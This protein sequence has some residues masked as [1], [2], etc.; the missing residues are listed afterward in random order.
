MAS[1]HSRLITGAVILS[2][3]TPAHAQSD[4]AATED[5]E[6]C[7]QIADVMERLAC[8][9]RIGEREIATRPAPENQGL[10][11]PEAETSAATE[12][13]YTEQVAPEAEI[14]EAA[15]EDTE[16]GVLTDDVGLPKSSDDYKPILVTVVRCNKG[17]DYKWYFYLENGQV[18]KY[19]GTRTLRYRSCNAPAKLIEDS[20]GFTLQMNGEKL[21]HRVQRVR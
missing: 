17:N 9:D 4:S 16:Y 11:V 6:Q 18:W 8:Y 20:F 3:T 14:S 13:G 10:V 21:K 1:I 7:R 19:L 15:D 2:L 12:P 5:I